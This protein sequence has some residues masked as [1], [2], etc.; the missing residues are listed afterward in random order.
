MT[1][2]GRRGNGGVIS[3]R[4]SLRTFIS[5]RDTGGRMAENAGNDEERKQV[6]L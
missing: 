3:Y 1:M 6:L 2:Q 5:L 4:C